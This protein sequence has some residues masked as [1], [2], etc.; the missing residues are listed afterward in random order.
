MFV[1]CSHDDG[2]WR[3]LRRQHETTLTRHWTGSRLR[4]SNCLF[5][6]CEKNTL[7]PIR[8]WRHA[9]WYS[10]INCD[11]RAGT[12]VWRRSWRSWFSYAISSFISW[13]MFA[14]KASSM[15]F[16]SVSPLRLPSWKHTHDMTSN[17]HLAKPYNSLTATTVPF[18]PRFAFVNPKGMFRKNLL[19]FISIF[20]VH[21]EK[22]IKDTNL[23]RRKLWRHYAT[24][25]KYYDVTQLV[26]RVFFSRVGIQCFIQMTEVF[27]VLFLFFSFVLASSLMKAP[28]FCRKIESYFPLYSANYRRPR[29]NPL[30][31]PSCKLNCI[32]HARSVTSQRWNGSSWERGDS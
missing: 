23:P 13:A 32:P 15:R 26:C 31:L 7:L 11:V 30:P 16:R 4:T 10:L 2:L 3:H 1:C 17:Y 27:C 9:C 12:C 25:V 6:I 14:N 29:V 19:L 24:R 21:N 20:L 18:S 22:N 5:F 28:T 8:K